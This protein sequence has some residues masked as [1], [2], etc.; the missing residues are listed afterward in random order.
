MTRSWS[1]ALLVVSVAAAAL[2]GGRTARALAPGG[3][4]GWPSPRDRVIDW[5]W[6]A[7]GPPA[8]AGSATT[9]AWGQW[10]TGEPREWAID[11]GGYA[12]RFGAASATTAITE[13][14][15]AALGAALHEDTRYVRCPRAGLGPRVAYALRMTILSRRRDGSVAFSVAKAASPFTGPLVTRTTL[16]PERYGVADGALSGAFALAMNAGWNLAYEFVLPAR[17]R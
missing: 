1:A 2:L 15:L 14:S 8:L 17:R 9:A 6:N 3:G 10:A 13:T 5:A 7:A 11:G 12:R 4:P 16:Y